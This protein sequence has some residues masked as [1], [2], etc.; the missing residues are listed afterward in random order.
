MAGCDASISFD[1][2][3]VIEGTPSPR[4]LR[5]AREWARLHRDDLSENWERARRGEDLVAIEPLL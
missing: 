5:L 1:G 3:E 2:L 4:A